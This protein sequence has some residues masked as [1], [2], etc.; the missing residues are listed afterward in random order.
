MSQVE[1]IERGTFASAAGRWIEDHVAIRRAGN[2]VHL[3]TQRMTDH[4][5]PVIGRLRVERIDRAQLI[6]LRQ[7]LDRKPL[8]RQTV[9]H[10]LADVRSCLRHAGLRPDFRA[11]MP[12]IVERAPRRLSDSHVEEIIRVLRERSPGAAFVVRLALETGLRWGEVH[13]LTWADFV[14]APHPHLVIERTKSGRVRRVPLTPALAVEMV[15]RRALRESGEFVSPTRSANA[16]AIVAVSS[17]AGVAPWHFHQLRHT[18]ACRWL[19]A[20]GGLAELQAILGHST[21]RMTE[22]YARLTDRAVF[23]AHE[24]LFGAKNGT[25]DGTVKARRK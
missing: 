10:I 17:R 23:A 20:G 5:L 1:E 9:A 16:C 8:S 7:H 2:A 22:R 12:R 15:H 24:L 14:E 19:E 13:R 6:R 11:V 21:V 25:I 18:F 3:A 4:V